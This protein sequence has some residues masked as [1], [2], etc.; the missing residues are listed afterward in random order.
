MNTL[1][2]ALVVLLAVMVGVLVWI[3]ETP[4][5]RALR[6]HSSGLS[7][8]RIADRLGVTRHRVRCW[9]A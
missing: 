4:Q 2:C 1:L 3:T 5:D 6:W 9:L 8:A 7:Q